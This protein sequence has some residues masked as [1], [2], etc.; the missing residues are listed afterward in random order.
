MIYLSNL[1][2][3]SGV[4]LNVVARQTVGFLRK[5]AQNRHAPRN[6]RIC[7]THAVPSTEH[8]SSLCGRSQRRTRWPL[9]WRFTVCSSV[10]ILMVRRLRL[11]RWPFC[12]EVQVPFCTLVRKVSGWWSLV[13]R[14]WR[15]LFGCGGTTWQRIVSASPMLPS[16]GKTVVFS[17][18]LGRLIECRAPS[19]WGNQPSSPRC[20]CND[21]NGLQ[22]MNDSMRIFMRQVE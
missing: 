21:A 19:G 17:P 20:N 3:K 14:L 18:S 1:V 4:D 7:A 5:P 22:V 2:F 8:V 11:R 16:A 13:A 10:F 15:S 9:K 12:L 6:A